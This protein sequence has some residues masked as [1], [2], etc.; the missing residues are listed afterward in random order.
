VRAALCGARG[1]ALLLPLNRCLALLPWPAS[2][3]AWAHAWLLGVMFRLGHD[4]L[5]LLFFLAGWASQPRTHTL[6]AAWKCCC[7]Q[8]RHVLGGCFRRARRREGLP[9]QLGRHAAQALGHNRVGRAQVGR[10]AQRNAACCTAHAPSLR[11]LRSRHP[12]GC[13]GHAQAAPCASAAGHEPG[14]CCCAA[15]HGSRRLRRLAA[16]SNIVFSN[17]L[18]DP[19]HG[20]GVLADVS[21]TVVSV[22]IPEGG[23]VGGAASAG[24]PRACARPAAL[25]GWSER[26]GRPRALGPKC[27]EWLQQPGTAQLPCLLAR[28]APPRRHP[29]ASPA[30]ARPPPLPPPPPTPHPPG[31]L[32]QGRT[33]WTS[34]SPTRTTPPPS[35]PPGRW[36]CS[37]CS[38]G[39]SRRTARGAGAP[40]SSMQRGPGLRLRLRRRGLLLPLPAAGD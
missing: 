25:R 37:T 22:I 21:D 28:A 14:A 12:L 13:V 2:A 31:S 39:W 26:Q 4:G 17:G 3:A 9:G 38:A 16:A 35:G 30:P 27:N 8:K 7:R 20:G 19:W 18:L 15:R 1:W 10:P 11:S 29:L 5:Q 36:S 34:C 33:T 24:G 40:G 23:S 6:R 32:P